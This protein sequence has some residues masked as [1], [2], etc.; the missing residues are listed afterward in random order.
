MKNRFGRL[1]L[2][3]TFLTG[4]TSLWTVFAQEKKSAPL[5]TDAAKVVEARIKS[6]VN[7]VLQILKDKNM[8]KEAKKVEVRKVVDPLFDIPLMA[9][10][11]LGRNHWPKFTEA[12][13]KEFTDL[14]V[15]A[16]QDSYFEKVELLTDEYVEFEKPVPVADKFQMLTHIV[17]KDKRYE[18][19]FKL[20][21]K[22]GDSAVRAGEW[23]VYDVEIEGI[24]FVRSYSNQYDQFLQKNSV[25]YLLKR[26][27]EKTLDLPEDLKA[28]RTQPSRQ[29]QEEK[30]KEAKESQ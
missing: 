17:A 2:L 3:L 16:L 27:R 12:Q 5:E 22:Q 29:G 14:F 9:K 26:L 4:L 24:S 1:F 23:Q 30:S 21:K 28:K 10:L 18:M 7:Q 13:R 20:Y 19:L 15:K 6:S 25:A 11:V 8:E